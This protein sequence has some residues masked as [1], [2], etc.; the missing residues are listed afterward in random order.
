MHK[1]P[2][3]IEHWKKY[4][5]HLNRLQSH[6]YNKALR[7]RAKKYHFRGRVM[8]PLL[9]PACPWLGKNVIVTCSL[10]CFLLKNVIVLSFEKQISK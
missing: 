5:K 9:A 3:V 7:Y 6:S 10:A 1:L 4:Y 8:G 2:S